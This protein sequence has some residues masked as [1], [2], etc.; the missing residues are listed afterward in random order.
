MKK[1][2]FLNNKGFALLESV[3]SIT[4]IGIAFT[5]FILLFSFSAND[6]EDKE[7]ETDMLMIAQSLMEHSRADEGFDEL[8]LS[9]DGQQR[10]ISELIDSMYASRYDAVRTVD[11]MPDTGSRLI[12]VVLSVGKKSRIGFEAEITLVTLISDI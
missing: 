7:S 12:R 2:K 11:Y 9:A 1:R 5:V 8:S 6:S 4:L 10:D 3:I